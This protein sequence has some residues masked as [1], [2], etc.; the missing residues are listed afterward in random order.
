[1]AVPASAAALVWAAVPVP[2]VAL[3]WV[4]AWGVARPRVGWCHALRSSVYLLS[5]WRL[6]RAIMQRPFHQGL[7]LVGTLVS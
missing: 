2:V 1:M 5:L 6:G 4:A 3:A 7:V